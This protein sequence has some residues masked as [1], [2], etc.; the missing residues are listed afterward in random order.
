[1][2]ACWRSD[3]VAHTVAQVAHAEMNNQHSA[4]HSNEVISI[5][6]RIVC[7]LFGHMRQL[8]DHIVAIS[9]PQCAVYEEKKTEKPQ[10]TKQK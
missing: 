10:A 8:V 2:L 6:N 4:R 5:C 7:S 9:Y 3:S 1:M